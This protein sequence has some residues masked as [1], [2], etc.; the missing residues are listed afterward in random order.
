M[1]FFRTDF[2]A[3]IKSKPSISVKEKYCRLLFS[4]LNEICA[5]I[6]EL[7]IYQKEKLKL[8]IFCKVCDFAQSISRNENEKNFEKKKGKILNW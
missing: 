1:K 5:L 6:A 3:Q 2:I 4:S 7:F 8:A